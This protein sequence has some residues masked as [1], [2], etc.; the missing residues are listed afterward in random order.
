[1]WRHNVFLSTDAKWRSLKLQERYDETRHGANGVSDTPPIVARVP[2]S[3]RG[4]GQDQEQGCGPYD[5]RLP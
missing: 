1:M 4:P 3:L 5:G 2:R